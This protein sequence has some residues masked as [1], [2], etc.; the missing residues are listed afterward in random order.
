MNLLKK[1]QAS[2]QHPP[3][4]DELAMRAY[5]LEHQVDAAHTVT[6]ELPADAPVGLAKIIVLFP[7]A[8]VHQ[9]DLAP[10]TDNAQALLDQLQAKGADHA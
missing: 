2:V 3:S 5:Q 6:F 4:Q 8:P 7:D 10:Q 9:A 1:P